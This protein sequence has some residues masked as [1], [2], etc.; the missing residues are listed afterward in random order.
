MLILLPPSEGKSDGVGP[1]LKPTG[2]SFASELAKPRAEVMKAVERLCSGPEAKA[3]EVLGV[4]ARQ[5]SEIERNAHLSKAPTSRAIDIYSGVLYDALNWSK[6]SPGARK[7]GE[8]S[9]IIISA[10]FGALRPQDFIPAYRLSMDV[11]LPKIGGLAKYWQEPLSRAIKPVAGELI[12]DCRSTTYLS[13]WSAP[14]KNAWSVKVVMEK[15]K[16]RSVVSHMAKQ[17]RGELAGLLLSATSNLRD[18]DDVA[19]LAEKRFGVEIT[20]SKGKKPGEL[21]LVVKG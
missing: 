13:A 6:L 9:L 14:L 4:S 21:L 15:G 8:R 16:K 19:D 20:D 2:L 12:I 11:T 17:Y 3:R 7:R 10:M 1:K 18:I 5:K